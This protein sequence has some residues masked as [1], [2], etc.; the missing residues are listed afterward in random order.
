MVSLFILF[1]FFYA[2][3]YGKKKSPKSKA[4]DDQCQKAVSD[5][6]SQAAVVVEGAAKDARRLKSKLGKI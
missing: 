6:I 4:V 5:A 1:S 2:K 3:S